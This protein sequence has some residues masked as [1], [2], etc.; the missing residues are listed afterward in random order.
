MSDA[1]PV[2]PTAAGVRIPLRV[3]PRSPRDRIDGLRAGRLLVRVTAPPVDAA[4]NDAVVTLFADK[5]N[6]P[7]RNVR[8]VSG[9]TSRNKTIEIAGVTEAALHAALSNL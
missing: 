9:A 1:L 4:A 7:R 8:I 6:V 5:L 3:V 2:T